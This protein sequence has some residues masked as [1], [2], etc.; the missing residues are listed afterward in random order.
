MYLQTLEGVLPMNNC[1]INVWVQRSYIEC[2]MC[3]L[4]IFKSV[5]VM[6][7][8]IILIEQIIVTMVMC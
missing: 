3:I 7:D 1:N 8:F 2:F 5:E 6:F 4:I